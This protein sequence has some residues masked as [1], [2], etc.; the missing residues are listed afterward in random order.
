MNLNEELYKL[1]RSCMISYFGV[2]DLSKVEHTAIDQAGTGIGY[3]PYCVTLG[4]SLPKDIVDRLPYR[5]QYNDALSYK[6]FAYDV[7]NQRLDL[8]ASMLASLIQEKGYRVLPISA[9]GTIDH[10]RIYGAF[11]HKL[12]ARLCGFGWIGKNC[13]LITPQNGPR[14]RWASILTDAP[15]QT[16]GEGIMESRCGKCTACADICPVNAIRGKAFSE[17]E[18][19]EMRFDAHKCEAYFNSL[20]AAG[21]LY[22]CGMCLYACPYGRK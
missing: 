8:T 18:S 14:V 20:T 5:E 12:G 2:A 9:S 21:K 16:T 3:Y 13:L 19:R 11:S 22:V 15:L 7:I 10:D 4:I 6:T 17:D 1:A